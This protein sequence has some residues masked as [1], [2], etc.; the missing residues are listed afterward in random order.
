MERTH[1]RSPTDDSRTGTTG[2]SGPSRRSVLRGVSRDGLTGNR[3][4]LGERRDSEG[5]K[6]GSEKDMSTQETDEYGNEEWQFPCKVVEVKD[7][8][9]FTV[10]IDRGFHDRSLKE[11]RLYGV[12]TAETHNTAHDSD[13]Y[14][15]GMRQT[16]FVEDWLTFESD[17]EFPFTVHT[18][19]EMGSFGRWLGDVSM[20]GIKLSEAILDEWPD[21]VY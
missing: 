4:L 10:M 17:E 14:K 7:G 18:Y 19:D 13:E 16:E 8:D 5:S 21:A 2:V 9:T 3:I 11:I 1:G 6:A 20:N 15:R 12:D